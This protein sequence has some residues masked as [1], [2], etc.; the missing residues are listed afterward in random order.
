MFV[1]IFLLNSAYKFKY[2][3]KDKI[4]HWNREFPLFKLWDAPCRC[5]CYLGKYTCLAFTAWSRS[6]GGG[7]MSLCFSSLSE[8]CTFYLCSINILPRLTRARVVLRFTGSDG[9]GEHVDTDECG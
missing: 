1:A 8:H 9:R 4:I 7:S 2:K 5:F 6:K 3:T